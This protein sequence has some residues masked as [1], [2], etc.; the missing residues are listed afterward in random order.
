MSTTNWED[1]LRRQRQ[2]RWLAPS[3]FSGRRQ[4]PRPT[5]TSPARRSSSCRSRWASRSPKAGRA[6]CAST[7]QSVAMRSTSATR[8]ST[9]GIMAELVAKAISDKPDVLVVHN[10]TVQLLARQIKQAEVGRHQGAADQPAVEPAVGRLRRR[11]LGPYRPRDRRGHRQGMRRRVSGK[12]GKVAIIPGQLTAADSV[13]M[14][15]AAFK[16][17]EQHKEIQVV[18]NQASDWEPEKARQITATV[19]QQHPDLLRHLRPLGRPHDGRRQCRQ[20]R[21][22]G[23]RRAGLFDGR[24]RRRRLQGDRGRRPGPHLE[25]R[26]RRPG[27]R[28]RHDDRPAAAGRRGCRRLDADRRIADEDHQGRRRLRRRRSAGRCDGRSRCSTAR[29]V[30]WRGS[31]EP[32]FPARVE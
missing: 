19:L 9:P 26:R 8:P 13:I 32:R 21:R 1:T 17:F 12:S 16:V 24:R 18:S 4:A 27:P 22:Q 20:G 15:E 23:R 25:L 29:A 28:R 2:R 31:P 30:N 11:Q 7:P 6:A 14:N 10:P 5:A 3:R